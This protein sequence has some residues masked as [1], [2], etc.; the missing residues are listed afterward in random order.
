[1][2]NAPPEIRFI[3]A[4]F[5]KTLTNQSSAVTEG[6]FRFTLV[7][8]EAESHKDSDLYHPYNLSLLNFR[9]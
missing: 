3:S 9:M 6:S 2:S 7:I 5:S 4:D 1:M 8:I